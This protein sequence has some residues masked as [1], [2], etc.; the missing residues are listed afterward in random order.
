[1]VHSRSPSI[2]PRR[3]RGSKRHSITHN[4]Y[5][6]EFFEDDEY[7]YPAYPH[8]E[9]PQLWPEEEYSIWYYD[10][11][12]SAHEDGRTRLEYT[13]D[14][15]I[16]DRG[17]IQNDDHGLNPWYPL[18]GPWL[19]SHSHHTEGSPPQRRKSLTRKERR[20]PTPHNVRAQTM[21]AD[22]DDWPSDQSL[23]VEE[24]HA[25]PRLQRR[26]TIHVPPPPPSTLENQPPLRRRHSVFEQPADTRVN[27]MTGT[28][29]AQP[30]TPLSPW[31]QHPPPPPPPSQQ[32]FPRIPTIAPAAIPSRPQP[33]SIPMMQAQLPAPLAP[34]VPMIRLQIPLQLQ[35]NMLGPLPSLLPPIPPA[36][37]FSQAPHPHALDTPFPPLFGMHPPTIAP[38][39]PPSAPPPPPPPT[40]PA[41]AP[42]P[43]TNTVPAQTAT[44]TGSNQASRAKETGE[45]AAAG[46]VAAAAT[47]AATREIKEGELSNKEDQMEEAPAK[48]EQEE[49]PV[50]NDAKN[51][52]ENSE[53]QAREQDAEKENTSSVKETSSAPDVQE[54]SSSPPKAEPPLRRS[55]SLFG[56]LFGGDNSA[57]RGGAKPRTVIQNRSM[58]QPAA[59]VPMEQV[60]QNAHKPRTAGRQSFLYP[61]GHPLNDRLQQLPE[62]KDGSSPSAPATATRLTRKES[63]RLTQKAKR[64]SGR[65]HIWCYR[66]REEAGEQVVWAAF[67]APNQ[68]RLDPFLPAVVHNQPI[69]ATPFTNVFLAKE[70]E[71]PG[72]TVVSP[73]AG[74]GYHFKSTFSNH[75]PIELEVACLPNSDK[76]MVRSGESFDPAPPLSFATT[77]NNSIAN[78]LWNAFF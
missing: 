51:E 15:I 3:R 18:G 17:E 36:L 13:Y 62:S 1:M 73:L 53:E 70:P 52:T 31:P 75:K 28:S 61:A 6:P 20:V 57:R 43:P 11:E 2:R 29:Q 58:W 5:E 24:Q 77:N 30:M 16:D 54:R 9:Y 72:T 40:I 33:P 76:L 46:A 39:I 47:A 71:L 23:F 42:A 49:E 78:K 8:W 35:S 64:L 50:A 34:M 10:D 60:L 7:Y 4:I 59:V 69:R 41:T 45:A 74:R 65:S 32:Q 67:D 66:P 37:Q 12:E 26:Q 55:R 22:A 19:P 63:M 44:Q 56:G 14:N 21:F 68:A 38:P 25:I 48:K 27:P